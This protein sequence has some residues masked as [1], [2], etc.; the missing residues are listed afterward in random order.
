MGYQGIYVDD[1]I[2]KDIQIVT[3]ISD[4]LKYRAKKEIGS[5]FVSVETNSSQKIAKSI[6]TLE[7]VV[8]NIVDDIFRKRNIMVNVVDI[9]AYDDYTLSHSI[10]VSVLSIIIGTV[11]GMSRS[12]LNELAMSALV[13]DIGKIFINKKLVSKADKLTF[14]EFEELKKHSHLGYDYLLPNALFSEDVKQGVLMHHEK[15]DGT[16]YPHGAKGEE[17]PLFARIIS[18]ADVYDALTSD[19]PYRR[20]LLPSDAME[21]IMSGYGTM[22]DPAIV[23]TFIRKVAPYPIGTCVR[24]NNGVTGIVVKNYENFF[25]RPKVKI[26]EDGKPTPKMIDL[27]HDVSALNI[28]IQEVIDI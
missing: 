24:L 27:A 17:I 4:E 10:N 21:Y 13:H 19:R 11:L 20:A 12:T 23:N 7:D 5:L 3:M 22:F 16:G 14:D 15:F 8:S 26:I 28:T 2:S 9:R 25:L 18:V 1:N 6:E